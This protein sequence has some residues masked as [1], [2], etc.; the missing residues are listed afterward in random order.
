MG[1][2]DIFK[3]GEMR[4][5]ISELE[6]ENRKLKSTINQLNEELEQEKLNSAIMFNVQNVEIAL[7]YAHPD[8]RGLLYATTDDPPNDDSYEPSMIYAMEP[9]IKP[10]NFES[11]PHPDY[12]PSYLKLEPEQ[13]HVYLKS[14][15]N[16]YDATVDIGYIFLLYY[17]LERQLY[18]GDFDKAFNVIMKLRDVHS[19]ASFQDYSA[20][21][22]LMSAMM[23]QRTDK[24]EEF[25]A[26]LEARDNIG[27]TCEM[28][29]FLK[30]F[31]G[32]SFTAADLVL[33]KN[34]FGYN[35]NTYM[36]SR[37][38]AFVNELSNVMTELFGTAEVNLSQFLDKINSEKSQV[39]YPYA[40]LSLRNVKCGVP[41][42]CNV[43]EFK[44][45]CTTALN[46][47]HENIK[48]ARIKK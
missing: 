20:N 17:G 3:T 45:L 22:L 4:R 40:N 35:K 26:S 37:Y 33:C 14:L 2:S 39:Y 12:W 36:D 38:E 25:Y 7:A 46:E 1:F 8:L 31:I 41:N 18:E 44:A 47:T 21:A 5:R 19:N 34:I 13:K 15:E 32:Q 42:I 48:R 23:K 27:V 29:I 16:P 9:V 43:T 11:V 30:A 28:Y 6:T 10:D 24:L